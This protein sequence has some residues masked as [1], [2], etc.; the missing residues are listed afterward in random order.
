MPGV[1]RAWHGDMHASTVWTVW[2]FWILVN[3]ATYLWWSSC[4]NSSRFHYQPGFN[5]YNIIQHPLTPFNTKTTGQWYPI[6]SPG[7][8]WRASWGSQHEGDVP[9]MPHFRSRKNARIGRCVWGNTHLITILKIFLT[10]PGLLISVLLWRFRTR[11]YKF[12]V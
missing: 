6:S 5:V 3:L 4:G 10:I 8:L 7:R 9:V 12:R 11:L 2:V 1:W